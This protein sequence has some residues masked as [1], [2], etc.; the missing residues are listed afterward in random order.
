MIGERGGLR[1]K[2]KGER[3]RVE[4]ERRGGEGGLRVKE[5]GEREG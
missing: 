2:E 1:V 4:G 3:G 5:E